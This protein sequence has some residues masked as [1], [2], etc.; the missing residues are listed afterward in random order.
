VSSFF[1]AAGAARPD[2]PPEPD[3][4]PP[5]WAVLVATGGGGSDRRRHGRHW[6]WPL[7]PAGPLS[8]AFAWRDEGVEEA[9]VEIDAAPIRA[10][11]ARATE[12]WPDDRPVRRS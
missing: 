5:P 7:P 4:R 3:Y 11:A 1:D 6:L 9:T 12:L 10:A 2:P 8:F